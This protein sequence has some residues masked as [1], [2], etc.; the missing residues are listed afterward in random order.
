MA[1]RFAPI[2][3]LMLTDVYKLGHKST[4]DGTK[5]SARGRLAVLR[6]EAGEL[7]L[8]DQATPEEEAAS[9]HQTVWT[10]GKFVVHQSFEDVRRVIAETAR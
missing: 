4:D 8:K 3:A 6:D 10:D 2:K 7:Y 5:K 1:N 9:V